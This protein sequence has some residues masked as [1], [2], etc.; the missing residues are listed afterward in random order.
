VVPVI[1]ASHAEARATLRAQMAAT[2]LSDLNK[3]FEVW[4]LRE[5]E[6]SAGFASI[7]DQAAKREGADQDFQTA[8][9][10]GFAAVAGVLSASHVGALKASLHRLAGRSSVVNGVPMAFCGDAVGILGVALGTRALAD[11]DVTAEIVEWAGRFLRASYDRGGVEDWRRCLLAVAGQHL[12]KPLDLEIPPSAVTAD[13]RTALVSRDILDVGDKGRVQE[14]A[15]NTLKLAIQ[16][17]ATNLTHDRAAL[18][19][20]ALEW[21]IRESQPPGDESIPIARMD[22]SVEWISP[23]NYA[24][25]DPVAGPL[26]PSATDS[27]QSAESDRPSVVLGTAGQP[28]SRPTGGAFASD[29]K[30]RKLVEEDPKVLPYVNLASH[31]QQA[32]AEGEVKF[33]QRELTGRWAEWR[34]V[35]PWDGERDPDTTDCPWWVAGAEYVHLLA[36]AWRKRSPGDPAKIETVLPKQI[37]LAADW[38]YWRKVYLHDMV[39]GRNST[40][41]HIFGG[42]AKRFSNIA[43]L[44]AM[45]KFAES[46]LDEWRGRAS[47]LAGAITDLNGGVAN[48]SA[49]QSTPDLLPPAQKNAGNARGA[50]VPSESR[51]TKS[52]V[53]RN[54]KYKVIDVALREIAESRPSRQEEVFQA[55]DGRH[56]V[57]PPAEPFVTARGW[58]AG[59]RRDAAAARAWLSKR[60]AELNLAPLPRGPKNP[61]K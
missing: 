40:V 33:R 59:F 43:F 28:G 7:V 2:C 27:A 16:E 53:R 17:P 39:F 6:Q 61:K 44:F 55:L 18:R 60:W 26:R 4:L 37:G 24:G 25:A 42:H 54:Q 1:T 35:Y 46:D 21:V 13:V 58:I 22:G 3:A 38:V 31:F 14:D 41:D 47:V 11:T 9:L 29:P 57:I 56:V 10:L 8:A 15:V 36:A 23:E 51:K 5:P 48:Q 52:P 12:G 49:S 19:L 50:Q 32:Q 45:R 34:G 30:I 20:A